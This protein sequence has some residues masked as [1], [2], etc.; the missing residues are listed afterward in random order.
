MDLLQS[1]AFTNGLE[2]GTLAK[3]IGVSDITTKAIT[4]RNIA[5]SITHREGESA[6]HSWR[7]YLISVTNT[8]TC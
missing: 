1:E 8:P 6:S 2:K 3:S 5:M 7:T 4:E